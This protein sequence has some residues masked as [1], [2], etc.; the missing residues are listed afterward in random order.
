MV[1]F[2]PA[3]PIFRIFDE[4]KAREYY[5]DFLGFDADF[6]HR[7]SDD[8]PLYLGI[9]RDGF[10]LH[11]SEHHGDGS[12]GARVRVQVSD[13]E[14]L[15][16]ELAAKNYGFNK[17]EILDQDWGHRE[18]IVDDPFGNKVVFCEPR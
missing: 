12:P 11:L 2:A 5:L 10:E 13:I 18:L 6:E 14:G 17:P 16:A 3:I 9:S 15:H 4:H 7:F 8:A 1:E